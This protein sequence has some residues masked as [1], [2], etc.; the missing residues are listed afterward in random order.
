MLKKTLLV[1]ALSVLA[2]ESLEGQTFTRITSGDIVNNGGFSWGAAWG[3]Y[4]NDGLIDLFVANNGAENNFLYRN[5]G[6][7]TFVRITVGDIVNDGTWSS[8]G[9]WGDYDN[10]GY[11]DLFVS[12]KDENSLLF[13]NNGDG[14]FTTITTGIIVNDA[15]NSIGASWGDYDNDGYLDLFVANGGENNFLYN[16]NR[17]GTFTKITTGIIVNDFGNSNGASWS[18]YDNDGYL[19]LFVANQGGNNFLYNNNG[20]GTFSK[21]TSGDIVNDGGFSSGSSWGDYDNDGD[22]DLFVANGAYIESQDNFLYQNNGDGNFIRISSGDIVNDGGNSWSSNWGDYDNDG[23]LDLFVTN[24]A[25]DFPQD[26]FLYSNN[27]DGTFIKISTGF[28]VTNDGISLGVS[29][30]DY[31][32]DGDLDLFVASDN[33]RNNLLFLNEGN[34]NNWINIKLVGTQS[35]NSAIGAKVRVKANINGNPIWQMNEI[36]GQTGGGYGGQNSLNA[37]FGLGDATII[38]SIKVEWLSGVEIFTDVTVNQFVTILEGQGITGITGI[39]EVVY[40]PKLFLLSQNYPNPF[41]A[42]TTIQYQL[43]APGEVL[44]TIYNIR[45]QEVLR[46][47]ESEQLA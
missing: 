13:S 26:N 14:T 22:L 19:D 41:N 24:S 1:V 32:N 33:S 27:G 8:A 9:S 23:D 15:G 39:G 40:A 28:I 46:I 29:S 36:S 37:E 38:D 34:A 18:D 43:A 3:D 11:L 17:D 35:N 42:I 25:G 4:D 7:G 45:G 16:N 12:N 47:V 44:L 2:L 10:D 31:D 30:A 21:I 6:D 20:D 5:N